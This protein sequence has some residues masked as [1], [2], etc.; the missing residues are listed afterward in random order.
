MVDDRGARDAERDDL[1]NLGDEPAP[2]WRTEAPDPLAPIDP[3]APVSG[4]RPFSDEPGLGSAAPEHDWGL[5]ADRVYP[6]LVPADTAGSPLD[7]LDV[8]AVVAAGSRGHL[9]PLLDPGP[10][11]LRVKYVLAEEGFDVTVNAE[12]MISWAI[13][14][15]TL[16]DASLANLARWAATAGWSVEASGERRLISSSNGAWDAS[17]VLLASERAHLAGELAGEGRVLLG[18]PERHLLVAG[19]LRPDDDEFAVLL[20]DFIAGQAGGADEPIDDRL[21]E[22]VGDQVMAF[23]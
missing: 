8:A 13:D 9:Q 17:R 21:L 23:R 18:L 20:A 11:G 15:T 7:E 4:H 3:N 16:R 10:A 1:R 22:L 14:A 5:A 6:V 12:H 2:A 19:A